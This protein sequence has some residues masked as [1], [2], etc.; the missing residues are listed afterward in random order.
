MAEEPERG[1]PNVSPAHP[2][3]TK[4]YGEMANR[5]PDL[6]KISQDANGMLYQLNHPHLMFD[7]HNVTTY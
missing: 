6:S 5:T 2:K 4:S 3:R 1:N 7:K